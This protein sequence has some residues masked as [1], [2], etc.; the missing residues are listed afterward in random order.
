MRVVALASLAVFA[1]ALAAIAQDDTSEL[2][3]FEGGARR[4]D[5]GAMPAGMGP[6]STSCA[7]CHGEI[8]AEWRSSLHAS[9]WTDPVFQAAYVREPLAFCR[10]CHAPLHEGD[11]PTGIAARD[12]VSCIVCHVRGGEILGTGTAGSRA[13]HPVKVVPALDT[14]AYCGSC[15]EFGFHTGELE[16]AELQQSTLSEWRARVG[17]GRTTATCQSCH[18]P[19]VATGGAPH[20]AHGFTVQKDLATIAKAVRVDVSTRRDGER[21]LLDATLLPGNIGHAFP[22]GDLYR[23][24][25]LRAWLDDEG[26]AAKLVYARAFGDRPLPPE[27]LAKLSPSKGPVLKTERFETSDTRVGEDPTTTRTLDLTPLGAD[28]RVVHW[29][30][31]YLLMPTDIARANKVSPETNVRLLHQGSITLP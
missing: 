1:L 31:D 27:A 3:L 19:S 22:T 10:N 28:T 16:T 24:L 26:N 23:R 12:G 8:A 11:R 14:S 30:L 4:L 29:R 5:V 18:M 15:H 13:P 17:D 20:R 21:V 2:H 7:Q 9:A 25:E 6:D